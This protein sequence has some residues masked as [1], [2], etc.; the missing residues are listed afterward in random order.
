MRTLPFTRLAKG[1][2]VFMM[3][4]R[5]KWIGPLN[6]HEGASPRGALRTLL[7]PPAPEH[8]PH[9]PPHCL[10]S[11]WHWGLDNEYTNRQIS[12]TAPRSIPQGDCAF[13]LLLNPGSA[14]LTNVPLSGWKNL[15]HHFALFY[16]TRLRLIGS[17]TVWTAQRKQW[18]GGRK[19]QSDSALGSEGAPLSKTVIKKIITRG[20]QK[21][22][23]VVRGWK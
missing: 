6:I 9:N 12:C 20:S 18:G 21:P 14:V 16:L 19:P 23:W 13:G 5:R 10:P 4:C 8:N 7:Q 22:S 15:V 2:N 11:T 3:C 17:K 1:Q